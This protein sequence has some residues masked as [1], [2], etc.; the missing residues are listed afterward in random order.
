MML[1]SLQISVITDKITKTTFHKS[2]YT[3]L[4]Q[5]LLFYIR[6]LR[7]FF[8]NHTI[9]RTKIYTVAIYVFLKYVIRFIWIQINTLN[10]CMVTLIFMKSIFINYKHYQFKLLPCTLTALNILLSKW[11]DQVFKIFWNIDDLLVILWRRFVCI[12]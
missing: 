8:K 10:I 3:C 11:K 7:I 2:A 9:F 5:S 12:P 1:I 6:N 4:L